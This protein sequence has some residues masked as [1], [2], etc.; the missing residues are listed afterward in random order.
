MK[1]RW[2]LIISVLV[3]LAL[4]VVNARA[5]KPEELAV[6]AAITINP[7]SDVINVPLAGADVVTGGTVALDWWFVGR[8]ESKTAASTEAFLR[9]NDQVVC[10]SSLAVIARILNARGW[11]NN[12]SVRSHHF[13]RRALRNTL[14]RQNAQ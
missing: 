14:H 10:M 11:S 3:V 7:G 8:L 12:L 4:H 6:K 9:H 1:N 5:Q 2:V 13:F